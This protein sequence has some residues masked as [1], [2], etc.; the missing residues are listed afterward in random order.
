M[1][2]GDQPVT[3]LSIAQK[4]GIVTLK[5]NLAYM[6]EGFKEVDAIDKAK[7]VAIHG[8]LIDKAF[9]GGDEYGM[10]ML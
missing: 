9:E 2:T 4:V 6:K 10:L 1:L 3:A 5:T 7:A 8:N